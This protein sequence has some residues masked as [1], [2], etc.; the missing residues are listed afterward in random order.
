MM[1]RDAWDDRQLVGPAAYD[2]QDGHEKQDDIGDCGLVPAGVIDADDDHEAGEGGSGEPWNHVG[3]KQVNG[4]NQA[5]GAGNFKQ[6]N[7]GDEFVAHAREVEAGTLGMDSG[8]PPVSKD[9]A[10]TG[11]QEQAGHQN[12]CEPK[13]AAHG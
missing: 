7:D 5:D 2:Y 10:E 6:R 4:Q 13:D 8:L 1:G 11:E 3:R 12:L 9:F